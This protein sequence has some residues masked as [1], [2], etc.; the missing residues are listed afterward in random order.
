MATH[1]SIGKGSFAR[2]RRPVNRR[3]GA[4]AP[5]AAAAAAVAAVEVL[6][7]RALLSAGDLDTTFGGGDGVVITD[8]SGPAEL[9]VDVAVLPDG[10][11]VVAGTSNNNLALVR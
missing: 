1:S 10:R 9:G 6:E 11:C 2:G 7:R 5:A 8:V 3:A 4:A